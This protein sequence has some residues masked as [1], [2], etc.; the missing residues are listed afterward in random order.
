MKSKELNQHR[1]KMRFIPWWYKRFYE[2]EK[3]V[4]AQ[5]WSWILLW[6]PKWDG[7]LITL[8]LINYLFSR[9]KRKNEKHKKFRI[10]IDTLFRLFFS[11][12]ESNKY[13]SILIINQKKSNF[14]PFAVSLPSTQAAFQ[15]SIVK[16]SEH[17]RNLSLKIQHLEGI[18]FWHG[19]CVRCCQIRSPPKLEPR[20]GSFCPAEG[21]HTYT[22]TR[23]KWCFAL[24]SHESIEFEP[25]KRRKL[26][27]KNRLKSF[28]LVCCVSYFFRCSS[29]VHFW[30]SKKMPA[31]ISLYSHCLASSTLSVLHTLVP[32]S[33][34]AA[35]CVV[36]ERQEG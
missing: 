1:P 33:A 20:H 7:E 24:N 10:V 31:I 26:S 19:A 11:A 21:V 15:P 12:K 9:I 22:H 29:S 18:H 6:A 32:A 13:L 16:S 2:S 14:F 8:L 3:W 34:S 35:L 25:T 28:A 36:E 4:K 23:R 27:W 17:M 30:C 5:T